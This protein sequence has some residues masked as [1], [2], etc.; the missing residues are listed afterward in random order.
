MLDWF[1]CRD[2]VI[3]PGLQIP[4]LQGRESIMAFE[5]PERFL[6]EI[7]DGPELAFLDFA[8]DEAALFFV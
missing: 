7:V 6:E 3:D 2:A 8:S 1:N 5:N 4:E